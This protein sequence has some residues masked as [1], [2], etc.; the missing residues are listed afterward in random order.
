MDL[1]ESRNVD[2]KTNRPSRRAGTDS[3]ALADAAVLAGTARLALLSAR[4]L[5]ARKPNRE[6]L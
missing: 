5:T 2:S 1:M 6:Q 3:F 4:L